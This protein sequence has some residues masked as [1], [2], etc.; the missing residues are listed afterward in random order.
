MTWIGNRSDLE[1]L[2]Y[3]VRGLDFDSN[4]ACGS[5]LRKFQFVV[6]TDDC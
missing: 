2:S 1:L 4:L 5:T 6:F 3:E